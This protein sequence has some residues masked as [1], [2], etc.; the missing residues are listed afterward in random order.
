MTNQVGINVL[1]QPTPNE[2]PTGYKQHAAIITGWNELNQ[3][4]NL[5]V[6]PDGGTYTVAKNAVREGVDDGTF[7]SWAHC[8]AAPRRRSS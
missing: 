7:S 4:A 1:Y 6:F 3:R 8:R 5:L 2:W